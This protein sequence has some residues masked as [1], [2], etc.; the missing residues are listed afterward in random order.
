MR[1]QFG[2]LNFRV[3][4]RDKVVDLEGPRH[5]GITFEAP[6]NSLMTS[7]LCE[8]FDDLLIANFTRTTL[9]GDVRSLYPDF[10]PYVA[11][12]GDNGRAFSVRELR[13]YFRAYRRECGALA[14]L[15]TMRMNSTQVLRREITSVIASNP[16]LFNSA[17]RMYR[18]AKYGG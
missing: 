14:Y 17:R 13:E 4:G 8:I 15:D 7:V 1:R 3:G 18:R 9:H 12:Y 2:F 5:R 10:T 11:K 16:A 6:R